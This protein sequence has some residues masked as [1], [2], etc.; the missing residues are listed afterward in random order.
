MNRTR[1]FLFAL[2]S[3]FVLA[4]L[5]TGPLAAQVGPAPSASPYRDILHGNRWTITAGQVFGNGGP[6][7]LS[8]N[9][10]MSVG[11]R[12]DIRL[13]GLLQGYAS[14]GYL[15]TERGL[16]NPDGLVHGAAAPVHHAVVGID[17]PPLGPD[18]LDPRDRPPAEPHRPQVVASP[19]PLRLGGP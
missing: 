8:P 17:Q 18:R 16:I 11:L 3:G 2:A 4:H 1:R 15:A 14:L 5:P 12:Y 7:G 19:G 6:L 13:S 9:S 10:G